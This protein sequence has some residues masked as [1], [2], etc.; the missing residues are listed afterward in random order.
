MT[1]KPTTAEL[2]EWLKTVH[3]V[4]IPVCFV[5]ANCIVEQEAEIEQLGC[6]TDWVINR[7]FSGETPDQD[8]LRDKPLALGLISPIEATEENR[9]IWEPLGNVQLGEVFYKNLRAST[10]KALQQTTE[11]E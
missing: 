5:A 4:G 9:S 8:D 1:N 11:T 10:R 7:L 6:F 3:S 2:V